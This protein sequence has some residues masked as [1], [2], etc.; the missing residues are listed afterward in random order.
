MINKS[1]PKTNQG[2]FENMNKPRMKDDFH[3]LEIIE[4][5]HISLKQKTSEM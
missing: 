3:K 1:A 4:I 2:I 5:T